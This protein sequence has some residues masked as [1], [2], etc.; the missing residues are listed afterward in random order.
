MPIWVSI[1]FPKRCLYPQ[2]SKAAC[3]R[4]QHVNSGMSQ[5][6]IAV[7]QKADIDN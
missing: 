7:F 3:H 5:T 2:K 4:Q 1:D 6:H